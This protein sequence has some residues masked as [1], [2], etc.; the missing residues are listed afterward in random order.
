MSG[1]REIFGPL[2]PL[3]GVW[4]GSGLDVVPDGKGGKTTTPFLQRLTFERAPKL[5]YGGQTVHALRYACLDWA[6]D[7]ESLFPV[8]EENGYFLWM[9]DEKR[10]TLQVSNPRGLSM[11]ASGTPEAHGAFT[12][13]ADQHGVMTT[14]YLQ[15][16]E[17]VVGYEAAVEHLA[18]DTIRYSTDVLLLLADN[19][20]FH[21]TD[22]TTL[23]RYA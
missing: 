23:K 3:I 10:I 13:A 21:Q 22:V 18:V 4:T 5:T 6:V 1:Y 2:A 9:P 12:V 11:L 17:N 14:K 19:S 20:I 16:F 7:G 8:Y 15:G